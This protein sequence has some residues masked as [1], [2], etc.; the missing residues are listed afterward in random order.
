MASWQERCVFVMANID[1]L[2]NIPEVSF[3]EKMTASEILYA[4]KTDYCAEHQRITGKPI[5]L[6]P[7]DKDSLKL[8][9]VAALLCQLF[10]C[11]DRAG[12]SNFLKFATGSDLENLAALKKVV[13]AAPSPAATTLRFTLSAARATALS[14]PKGT[15]A[16]GGDMIY[17]ATTQY[18]EVPAGAISV[19]VPAMCV[20]AGPSANNIPVDAMTVLVDP[21]PYVAGVTNLTITQGGADMEDD[22]SLT[23]RAYVAQDGFSTAATEGG[24]IYWTKTYNGAIADVKVVS[25]SAGTIKIM[26][27][28]EGGALPE[29]AIMD[30]LVPYLDA[31]NARVST[32]L[33]LVSAPDEVAFDVDMTYYINNADSGQAVNIQGAVASAVTEYSAWQRKIGRDINPSE[34]TKRVIAVGAKRVVIRS[35]TY[36]PVVE[37][38]VARLGACKV[39]YGGLEND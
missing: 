32:D 35:P 30:G 3:I 33:V 6:H 16:S 29:R 37:T 1:A 13:R 11:V 25:P 7:A 21:L 31:H 28:M 8:S 20:R 17:F 36:Q 39:A 18:A 22:E 27:L 15:R 10:H 5:T 23:A 12:K 4:M 2:K 24:C 34:L 26:F 9:A 38:S 19:D 14:V